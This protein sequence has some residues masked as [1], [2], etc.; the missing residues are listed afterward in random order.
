M[1]T[2]RIAV[3]GGGVSGLAASLLLARDGHRVTL[4]ER[5]P[6]VLTAPEDA[7]TCARGGI[8]HY[9]QPHAFIPRGRQELREHLAGVYDS[10]LAAGAWD[11]DVSCKLPGSRVPE[12]ALLQYVAVRRPLIEWGLRKAA[13]AQ[14]GIEV[15]APGR[16]LGLR[17]DSGRVAGLEADGGTVDV[18]V[19]VDAMGRRSPM[20][21]WLAAS[22]IASTPPERS[23][24]GVIYYSRYYRVRPGR[25]L[26][27]GPW[28]L[29]PRGDL[30]YMGY[31]TF[32][33]DNRTFAAVLAI[34]T[35]VA[36][37]KLFKDERA[38]EVGV[39][40]LP[41]LS[42]WA[43]SELAEPITPVLAMGGLQNSLATRDP[44]P[45]P[46]LFAVG[47]SACHT[48]PVLAHGLS[49]A[50]IHAVSAAR[51][52]REHDE[53]T[54]ATVAHA[55]AIAPALRERYDLASALDA[56]RLRLWTGDQVD[57]SRRNQ[58]YEL[59]S[60][61]AAGAV[62]MSDPDVFRVFVRRFGLL[63]D[64]AVL[65]QDAPMLERI[66]QRFHELIAKPRPAHGPA[67]DEMLA[68]AQTA[69]AR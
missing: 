69:L 55:R 56:Q 11:V 16:A 68:R 32:P 64:T 14:P 46:G 31:S 34:P 7:W 35:G 30:G 40:Q 22:G 27:D 51:A 28:L 58:D 42:S 60:L 48:D 66:E 59:F 18:D 65:D 43:S 29:G 10:L 24:C 57:F 49:F 4:I 25:E 47:D 53:L 15:R 41:L 50:L 45:L 8:P 52:L 23:E 3:L 6:V 2:H 12:D 36:D 21:E 17:V 26:P 38:F 9:L 33:G 39:Q 19:V 67:R 63:D 37:L 5:D 61:F 54:D 20:R 44:E 62:A 13:L 1:R